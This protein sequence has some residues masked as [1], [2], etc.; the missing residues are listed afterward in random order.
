MGALS[1]LGAPGS[2][3]LVGAA[4]FG[5]TLALEDAT[6]WSR[7]R[8]EQFLGTIAAMR[9]TI[10]FSLLLIAACSGDGR[11]ENAAVEELERAEAADQQRA[12]A[13]ELERALNMA[14]REPA[15]EER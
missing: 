14:A 12:A 11:V 9:V 3:P 2:G 15:D 5:S 13:A 1:G 6:R 4:R 10:R 8:E 7:R